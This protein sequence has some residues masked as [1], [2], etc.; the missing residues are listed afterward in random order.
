MDQS[1]PANSINNAAYFFDQ[2][3]AEGFRYVR[4]SRYDAERALHYTYFDIWVEG[5]RYQE[6]HV[7][8]AYTLE[9]IRWIIEKSPLK[10]EAALDGFSEEA[11]TNATER[12]HWIVRKEEGRGKREEV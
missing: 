6:E 3:E 11:A 2:G 1:A 9:E 5:V 10:I 4:D 12:I 7:Q 8:R